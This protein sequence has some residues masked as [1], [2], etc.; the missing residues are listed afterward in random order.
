MSEPPALTLVEHQRLPTSG[1]RAVL[2]FDI[3]GLRLA[4][5]KLAADV[6]GTPAYMN[7]G[8]SD[9]D[10]LLYRWSADRFAEES[11]LRVP[12]GEDAL[13]FRIGDDWFLATA[14]IRTGRGPYELN[15]DS[16]IYK[17]ARESW[18]H[19]QSIPTFA[20]RPRLPVLR[21]GR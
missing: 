19:F 3:D 1:A 7:G 5:P 15:T 2:A 21:G 9:V 11:R 6:P 20:G 13:V 10:M 17:R 16:V 8:D 12:G 4:V 18:A 14:S